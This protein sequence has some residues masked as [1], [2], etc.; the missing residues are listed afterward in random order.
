MKILYL[1]SNGKKNSTKELNKTETRFAKRKQKMT[2][3]KKNNVKMLKL[4]DMELVQMEY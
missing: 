1:G 4:N 2:S 3:L